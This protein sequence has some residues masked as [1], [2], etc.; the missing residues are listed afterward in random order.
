MDSVT[1]FKLLAKLFSNYSC[2]YRKIVVATFIFRNTQ[3]DFVFKACN[4]L[5]DI[6]YMT[7]VILLLSCRLA[8]VLDMILNKS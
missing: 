5:H 7:K 8:N 6:I 1:L 4:K 2:V 3:I